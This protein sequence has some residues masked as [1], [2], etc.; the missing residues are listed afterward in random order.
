MRNLSTLPFVSEE[1][2]LGEEGFKKSLDKGIL[3]LVLK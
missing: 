1:R 2:K 3:S